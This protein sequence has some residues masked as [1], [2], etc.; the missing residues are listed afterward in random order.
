VDLFWVFFWDAWGCWVLRDGFFV[1]LIFDGCCVVG[2]K[3]LFHYI[4]KTYKLKKV[5]LLTDEK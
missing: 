1:G 2:V 5:V 4:L 3:V